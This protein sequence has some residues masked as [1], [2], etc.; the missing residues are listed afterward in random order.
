M[1]WSIPLIADVRGH[2]KVRTY[3]HERSDHPPT[4]RTPKRPA[5]G[6]KLSEAIAG[7]ISGARLE[8]LDDCGHW[9]Q[10]EHALRFNKI[11]AEFLSE[12]H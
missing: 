11:V 7:A 1:S 6:V 12:L 3:G 4:G 2:E 8:V 10:F 5:G 9:P